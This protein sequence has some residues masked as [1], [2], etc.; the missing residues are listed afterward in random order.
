[1]KTVQLSINEVQGSAKKVSFVFNRNTNKSTCF[2]AQ[3]AG[4]ERKKKI[5]LKLN[6]GK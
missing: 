5:Q 1:M 6:V 2:T 4:K 3:L